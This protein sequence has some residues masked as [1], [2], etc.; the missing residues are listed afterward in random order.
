MKVETLLKL[1]NSE[2]ETNV[3]HESDK[4][5]LKK[6]IKELLDLYEEDNRITQRTNVPIGVPNTNVPYPQTFV[7]NSLDSVPYCEICSCN[8]KNGGS[9]ICGCT[10]A[11]TLVPRVSSS[12]SNLTNTI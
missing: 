11:N 9:G 3:V 4:N 6:R 8:P 1:I 2:L 5:Y 10:M 7:T 12:S